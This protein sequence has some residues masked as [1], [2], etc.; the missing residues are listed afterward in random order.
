M[1]IP[2]IH[3]FY[4]SNQRNQMK[5]IQNIF[6]FLFDTVKNKFWFSHDISK[7]YHFFP[8][9]CKSYNVPLFC[10]HFLILEEWQDCWFFIEVFAKKKSLEGVC[11]ISS[12]PG[13]RVEFVSNYC[14]YFC[15]R[16]L[17]NLPHSFFQLTR[18]FQDL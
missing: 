7:L 17:E 2:A 5:I 16:K 15:Q 4:L 13:W 12:F 1:L 11:W 18:D 14:Y 3:T 9:V 8:A 10:L 6:V